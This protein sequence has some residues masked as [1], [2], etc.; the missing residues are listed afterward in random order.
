[1]L[2]LTRILGGSSHNVMPS[3]VTIM[4]TVRTFDLAVQDRLESALRELVEGTAKAAGCSATLDYN[5]YYPA[6]VNDADCARHA[7]AAGKALLGESMLLEAPAFTSED[8]AFMLN[9]VPGA[10]VWLGQS[11]PSRSAALHTPAYDFNDEVLPVGAGLLATLAQRRCPARSEENAALSLN[12]LQ[13]PAR[14]RR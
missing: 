5:R 7:L 4:G 1:V 9:E 8:F 14:A 11:S 10:Y 2:S 13:T 12:S 3:E 6:T